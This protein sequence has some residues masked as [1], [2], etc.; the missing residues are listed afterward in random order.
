MY[1][2]GFLLLIETA[3][4]AA[5]RMHRVRLERFTADKGFAH[6]LQPCI[7]YIF[8]IVE[9]AV[10]FLVVPNV[11]SEGRPLDFAPSTQPIH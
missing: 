11:L 10:M 2:G 4:A 7:V 9:G 6:T 8:A 5:A 3:A 1:T